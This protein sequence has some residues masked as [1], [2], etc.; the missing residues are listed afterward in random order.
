M[1][2]INWIRLSKWCETTGD[3]EDAV[4][5][6]RRAGIWLDEVHCRKAG[7]GRIWINT[8]EAMRWVRESSPGLARADSR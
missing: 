4:H 5:A 2:G 8:D 3:T 1:T 7:D 6:R